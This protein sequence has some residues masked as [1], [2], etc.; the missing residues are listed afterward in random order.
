MWPLAWTP[1]T[2]NTAAGCASPVM[3]T[4]PHGINRA[5]G[6]DAV[7]HSLSAQRGTISAVTN[8]DQL[9]VGYKFTV[10]GFGHCEIT[11]HR[12]QTPDEFISDITPPMDYLV[13]VGPDRAPKLMTHEFITDAGVPLAEDVAA[14]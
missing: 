10:P 1:T 11:A 7:S 2:H 14:D 5:D 6:T 13:R 4:G 8:Q 9:P 3:T 12:A